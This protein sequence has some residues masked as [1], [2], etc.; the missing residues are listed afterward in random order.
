MQFGGQRTDMSLKPIGEPDN[1]LVKLTDDILPEPDAVLVHGISPQ[2]AKTNGLCE[3]EFTEFL[4]DKVFLPDTIFVGF[5]SI[6]FDDEFMRFTLWRNFY[7]AYEWQW[8]NNCSR[9]DMLDVAR[10]TRALRPNGIKWPFDSDGKP[11]NR[12][13]LLSSINKLNH[14][15]AHDALSDVRATIAVAKLIKQKQPKLFDYLL[16]IRDKNK[17]AVLVGGGEPFIYTSGYYPGE[18]EKT[19]IAV[20]VAAHPLKQ[21]AI[22]YDL[23]VDPD[24]FTKLV[25][26]ELAECWQARGKDAPYFPVKTLSYN[27]CPAVAPLSV[28]DNSSAARLKIDSKIIDANLAKL[29]KSKDFGDKLVRAAEI[30]QKDI[31]VRLEVDV[32]AETSK[33]FLADGQLY[34]GFINGLDK[35]KTSVVRAADANKLADLHLDFADERLKTLLPLYKARNYPQSLSADEQKTWEEFR[36]QRLLSGGDTSRA[37]YYFKRLS[38]LSSQPKLSNQAK[39]LLKELNVYGQSIVPET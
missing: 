23:R 19:T 10:M 18:Y 25:P 16:K 28:L 26:A 1:V 32:P 35:T 21:A 5:N 15:D 33:K 8:K 11:S 12:L 39:Y 29:Q 31:Q 36:R 7:D 9:W 34:E 13:G 30:I 6:R 20:M 38:E 27:R 22:V 14:T 4:A 2:Q 24:K 17:V 37:A 3:A